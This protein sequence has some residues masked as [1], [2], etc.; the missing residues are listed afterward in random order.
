MCNDQTYIFEPCESSG[1]NATIEKGEAGENF[2]IQS[3]LRRNKIDRPELGTARIVVPGGRECRVEMVNYEVADKLEQPL[4]HPE[5]RR[6][7]L[8]K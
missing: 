6:C 7:R 4:V 8:Y 2:Q 5:C 1:G 3:L